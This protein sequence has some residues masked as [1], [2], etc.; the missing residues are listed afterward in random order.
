M[1]KK[2][3]KNMKNKK[4]KRIVGCKKQNSKNKRSIGINMDTDR[5][6]LHENE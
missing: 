1:E 5:K 4:D 3:T 2:I 6:I